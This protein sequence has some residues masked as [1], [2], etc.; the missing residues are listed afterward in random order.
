MYEI[1]V[2]VVSRYQNVARTK[3]LVLTRQN[4]CLSKHLVT[5][6]RTFPYM[7]YPSCGRVT[8]RLLCSL[9]GT[10]D[11]R[12]LVQRRLWFVR[13]QGRL[14]KQLST[15]LI[16]KDTEVKWQHWYV[17]DWRTVCF[18]DEAIIDE[19]G[20]G[21]AREYHGI[22]L[23]D[24]E[25]YSNVCRSRCVKVCLIHE[26]F[27]SFSNIVYCSKFNI[28]SL[29][30][31]LQIKISW[32]HKRTWRPISP[33]NRVQCPCGQAWLDDGRF[34]EERELNLLALLVIECVLQ[35]LYQLSHPA[36]INCVSS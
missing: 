23:F 19:R 10:R 3:R 27:V 28:N 25:N 32:R 22:T 9:W 5:E 36:D 7:Y 11:G 8:A 1:A 33:L 2:F 15:G 18:N 26:L 21:A 20:R 17:W 13:D 29:L 31:Y 24:G 34:E 35:L 4:P 16:L 12:K 14:K 6:M 30:L